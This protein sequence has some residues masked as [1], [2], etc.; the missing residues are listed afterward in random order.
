MHTPISRFLAATLILLFTAVI[1]DAQTKTT[2]KEPKK[3]VDPYETP[4][5]V[6]TPAQ[7]KAEFAEIRK[8]P[9][10]FTGETVGVPAL[11]TPLLQNK[12][13]QAAA[14]NE[15]RTL[16]AYR[17]VVGVPFDGMSLD[18][19]QTAHATACALLLSKL[20]RL[21][22]NPPC[23]PGVSAE[24]HQFGH[25]GAASSNLFGGKGIAGSVRGYMNDSDPGN[26]KSV[27]HRR[28][29]I[30]P[31]MKTTGFGEFGKYSAMWSFDGSRDLG[32]F[33][34]D[35]IA[36]PA[37]GLT[38]ANMLDADWAWNVS[39]NR[40]KYTLAVAP[41]AVKV[42]VTPGAINPKTAK[43]KKGN[44]PMPVDS[45]RVCQAGFGIAPC[46]IFRPRTP[47]LRVGAAYHVEID[48][49]MKDGEETTIEYWVVFTQPL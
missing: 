23:P 31:G 48:G 14:V 45:V 5:F 1:A 13:H 7:L 29:C 10:S 32:G 4:D 49:F 39:L 30:N 40:N 22:H 25:K 43:F 28:W 20:D 6:K 3:K 19:Q 24:L 38:P 15:L 36:F 26:I 47:Q 18:R 46:V 11:V 33:D 9:L 27:G 8:M 34:Y 37:R 12:A 21:D 35:F 44:Q 2:K 42:R 16:M 17:A 41:E